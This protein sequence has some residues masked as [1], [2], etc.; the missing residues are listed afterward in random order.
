MPSQDKKVCDARINPLI[1]SSL[2]KEL[3]KKTFYNGLRGTG[4]RE[5][6]LFYNNLYYYHTQGRNPQQTP[7]VHLT[8]H[9]YSETIHCAIHS[10]QIL[11]SWR[12]RTE[13]IY[14]L[15]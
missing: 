4:S 6:F 11:E 9:I 2:H 1:V 10:I 5:G 3:V 13:P 12:N 8:S 15:D 14:F 7:S